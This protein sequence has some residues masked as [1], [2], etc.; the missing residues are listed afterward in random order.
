VVEWLLEKGANPSLVGAQRANEQPIH[1][2]A[3]LGNV[4]I[5][6]L[7]IAHGADPNAINANSKESPLHVI[8]GAEVEK[9]GPELGKLHEMRP[10]GVTP[11]KWFDAVGTT[12][13]LLEAGTRI[14]GLGNLDYWAWTGIILPLDGPDFGIDGPDFGIDG[15]DFGLDGP[16]FGLDG[17]HSGLDGPDFGLDRANFALDGPGFKPGWA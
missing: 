16:D 13:A 1:S 2:A 12:K 6:K 15:P 10:K 8:A 9:W 5:I 14:D 11:I 4:A 3:F 17:P 7:L